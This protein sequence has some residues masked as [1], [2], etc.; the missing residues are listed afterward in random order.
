[1]KNSDKILIGYDIN[2]TFVQISYSKRINQK[3]PETFS[4]SFQEEEYN[5]P[6]Q[7]YVDEESRWY[8]GNQMKRIPK[9]IQSHVIDNV[10]QLAKERMEI[11]VGDQVY[12][13]TLVLV[14]FL[15]S[16]LDEFHRKIGVGY[17]EGVMF[18]VSTLEATEIALLERLI[19]ELK[20]YA[21]VLYYQS[22][23]ESFFSYVIHQTPELWRYQVL[24]LDG[25]EENLKVYGFSCDRKTEPAICSVEEIE[26]ETFPMNTAR[27]SYHNLEI[28][29]TNFVKIVEKTV[30]DRLISAVY[31]LGEEMSGDWT[32]LGTIQLCRNRKVFKGNNLFSKGACL[33]AKDKLK[34]EPIVEKYF[35]L[36]RDKLKTNLGMEVVY[37][38]KNT[39]FPL[40]DAGEN[41][42]DSRK[43]FDMI[44]PSGNQFTIIMTPLIGK[45]KKQMVMTLEGLPVRQE[46]NTRVR[47]EIWPS[48]VDKIHIRVTDLGF[49]D[50]YKATMKVWEESFTVE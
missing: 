20:S 8:F 17:F 34:P 44:L 32:K 24:A 4:T 25:V 35:Y 30:K 39:Y 33:A 40:I 18:T 1:M 47:L 21:K 36:G 9:V 15:K 10:W 26:Y 43:E 49:G 48:S 16:T 31:L 11:E 19:K 46:K 29:S 5:I 7:C 23:A 38:G 12:D 14:E 6:L 22:K 41:W 50:F 2:E 28:L 45:E 42:Y 27:G 3:N 37:R 13:S